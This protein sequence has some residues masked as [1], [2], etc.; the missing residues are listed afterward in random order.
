M[1]NLLW[2]TLL[3]FGLA[4]GLKATPTRLLTVDNMQQVVPDDW[5]ATVYYSLSPHFQGHWYADSYANGKDFGWA[6]LDIKIGTLV[7]WFNKDFEGDPLYDGLVAKNSIGI[8]NTGFSNNT[9]NSVEPREDRIQD[10]DTKIGLGYAYELLDSLNV[11]LCFRYAQQNNTLESSGDAAGSPMNLGF[12]SAYSTSG[13]GGAFASVSQVSH[14]KD[15][16]AENAILLS[17]QFSYTGSKFTLDCK[18][19]MFWPTVNNRHDEDVFQ[20]AV[21]HGSTTQTL[22]DRGA[23]NWQLKPKLRYMLSDD[24]SVVLRGAYDKLDLSTDHRVSGSFS[25]SYASLANSY[26]FKDAS[27]DFTLDE[28][29]GFLG[30]VKTWERGRD[31]VTCGVGFTQTTL[32]ALGSSYQI[33]GGASAY[34]D[35]VL[36]ST[37]EGQDVQW[38]VPVMLGGEIGLS[39]WAKARAVVQ[40]NFFSSD[41][42]KTVT[43][44]YDNQGTLSS[45]R[46]TE[47]TGDFDKG[48]AFNGGFGFSFGSFN[49]DTALNLG[50]LSSP[51][52]TGFVNPLYQSSFTYAF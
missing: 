11:A 20:N 4:A 37:Q 2:L 18:F 51:N 12:S 30:L 42:S 17:P 52:G 43:K 33:R 36:A 7:L 32:K 24:S 14:A 31:L 21:N 1:K 27:Q 41:D 34:D 28:L 23:M 26:D 39:P 50:T 9:F 19:D 47:A 40:R 15:S 25:G 48:W 44:T 38:V 10:P 22:K 5:D 49:W 3:M 46:T 16:Q 29:D 8:N 35:T 13:L 6:F 45:Q